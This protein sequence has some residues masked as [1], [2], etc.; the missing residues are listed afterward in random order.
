MG[1]VVMSKNKVQHQCGHSLPDLFTNYGTERQCLDALFKRKWPSGFICPA[2][3]STSYCTLKSRKLYQC[4]H[5]HHQT[6]VMANTIFESSKLPLTTWFLSVHLIT[7]SKAGVSALSLKRQ[8]GVSYNTAWRIKQKIM[9]VMKDQDDKRKLS[10]IVQIDDVYYGGE[11]HGGKRVRGS[12]NKKPFIAAVATNEQ[13][14]P[15]YMNFNVVKG[16]K[17]SEIARWAKKHLTEGCIL[18]DPH[19]IIHKNFPQ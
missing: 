4:N 15:I 11:L 19:S 14:H 2:C 13:G 10:G 8:I 9:Q 5:C 7:Q 1:R 6:S 18:R 16:F 17:L 12:E 3:A